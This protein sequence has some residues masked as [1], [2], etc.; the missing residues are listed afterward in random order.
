MGKYILSH[1]IGT[2][3][4]KAVLVD[5]KGDVIATSSKSLSHPLSEPGLGGTESGRILACRHSVQP[6]DRGE[7]GNRSG[8]NQRHRLLHPGPGCDS[9]G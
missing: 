8:R 2:S 3:S 9:C 5:F 7:D 4:D 6:R 1:D